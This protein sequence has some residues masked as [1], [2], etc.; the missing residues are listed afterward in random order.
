MI[1]H[2]KHNE[3]NKASWDNC[4]SNSIN[5]IAYAY[6]WYLDIVHEGWEALV[7]DDYHRVMPLTIR[8]KLGVNYLYQP[9]FV[10]QLGVFSVSELNPDIVEDFINSIPK[11]VRVI[12]FNLNHFNRV[13]SFN[14]IKNSNY[15]LDLI[16]DYEKIFSSYSTNTKRNLKKAIKNELQVIKGVNP[17]ELIKLFRDNKG[18][19]VAKWKD[20][21]YRVLTRLIYTSIH[22]GMGV[23]YGVYT[24]FNELCAAA[25]FLKSNNRIIFLFSG[26]NSNAKQNGAMTFLIDSVIKRNSPGLKILDFEGSND[27]NLARFYKGFGALQSEYLTIKKNNFGF[28]E[29]I[30]FKVYN[31]ITNK[32]A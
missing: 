23:T 30:I 12:D 16:S 13:N 8:S 31:L 5:S 7:E 2:L 28:V 27:S 32:K 3:I 6:S 21:N 26:A 18:K 17:D 11:E 24:K 29:H 15:L 19:Y 20:E 1:V 10:Q 9:F 22:K 14:K 25:F 4:I